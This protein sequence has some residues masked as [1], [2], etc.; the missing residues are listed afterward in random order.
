VDSND[1]EG[2]R[3]FFLLGLPVFADYDSS[4]DLLNPTKGKRLRVDATPFVGIEDNGD[5]P[6]FTRVNATGSLYEALDAD[7]AYVLAA[8]ARLG[9]VITDDVDSVPANRRLYSGGGGSVRGYAERSIGP[10]DENGDPIGGLSV[11]E[12]GAELRARF[13]GDIGGALFV[14]AGEVGTESWPTF[15]EGVQYAAGAGLRYF[16]P[17]GPI[18]VDLGVPLNPRDSDDNFQIYLSIGQAY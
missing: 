15:E 12:V 1:G 6:L 18:R 9:S 17:I 8:R 2:F 7:G 3:D 4:D 16:S 10:L 13:A 5:V 14:E 11:M